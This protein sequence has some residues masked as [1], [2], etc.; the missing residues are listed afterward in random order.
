MILR[1]KGQWIRID[2]GKW[3]EQTF[4]EKSVCFKD[5]FS[6]QTKYIFECLKDYWIGYANVQTQDI[7]CGGCRT[8]EPRR[9]EIYEV[10]IICGKH[11]KGQ[12]FSRIDK[13][14]V[15][16]LVN[17]WE[18][19]DKKNY[20]LYLDLGGGMSQ[21]YNFSKRQKNMLIKQLKQVLDMRWYEG[22]MEED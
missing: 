18:F 12:L 9:N 19:W 4:K 1:Y 3:R 5:Y 14:I 16:Q 22:Q 7:F 21:S 15:E 20:Y 13:S 10:S 8:G 17:D 2:K 11:G 6:E